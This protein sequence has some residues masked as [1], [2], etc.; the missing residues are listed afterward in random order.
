[1]NDNP[2]I[3]VYSGS[4]AGLPTAYLEAARELGREIA[5]A[6][7]GLVYGAGR[8]GMMGAVADAALAAGA[9]VTGV[10]PSF[11]VERGWHHKGLTALEITEGM[12]ARK[13]RMLALCRG[14]IALPG[15]IGT[16]E[17]IT[18]AITWR[19]LGLFSGNVVIYNYDGYYDP[20]ISQLRLAVEKS[21]MKPDHLA[22]VKVA[23]IATDAVAE[24]L[25]PV[26]QLSFT[27]KF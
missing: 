8:T 25:R 22:V 5:A 12:H 3:T 23:A 27:P 26:A 6:G 20:F 24:A 11:M 18:E 17:E 13:A 2:N 15:G 14:V 10:I 21:F 19:Q 9:P 16:F 7:A 1:M 4:S